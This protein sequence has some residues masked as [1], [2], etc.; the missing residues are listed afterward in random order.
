VYLLD[1][2]LSKAFC[3]S[4]TLNH[5]PYKENRNLVGTARYTS[6]NAHLGIEQ[7]RR[8]DLESFGYCLIYFLKGTL[9][10]QGLPANNK[11]EKLL[12][13]YEKKITTPI[14]ELCHGLPAEL[15]IYINY[16]RR[17][18]FPDKADYFFLKKLFR[19]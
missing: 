19:D 15:A 8:D 17:L 10:W 4:K 5:F 3:D 9:P 16:C 12:K 1:F 13:I 14:E 6:I 2:N 11:Q 18:M 7:A